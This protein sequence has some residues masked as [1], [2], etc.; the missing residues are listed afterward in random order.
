MF[1]S[2]SASSS[3][4][5]DS[6]YASTRSLLTG[7]PREQSVGEQLEEECCEG[8]PKLTYKQ[9]LVGF[10]ACFGIGMLIEFGSFFR[11]VQLIK[12][13]PKP[14]VRIVY[15][16]AVHFVVALQAI[17]YTLGNIIAIC[18]SFFL[19]GPWNQVKRMFAPTRAIATAIYLTSIFATLFCAYYPNIPARAGLIVLL[20]EGEDEEESLSSGET[21]TPRARRRVA[22]ESE[23]AEGAEEQEPKAVEKKSKTKD[24]SYVPTHGT[25]YLHD[26]RAK[27]AKPVPRRKR[28]TAGD[29]DVW[30]HDKY[31]ELV[32]SED[33]R[34]AEPQRHKKP[35]QS[36]QQQG[37]TRS[38]RRHR[39]PP[40]TALNPS[41][42]AFTPESLD[43][44]L[45]KL[46][47]DD[48]EEE[49]V[50][51]PL[52]PKKSYSAMRA[53]YINPNAT[54]FEASK[55]PTTTI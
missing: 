27:T 37:T 29:S 18:S 39:K 31:L 30:L 35:Q 55:L 17:C 26:D 50:A 19:S 14:F 9:R 34:S 46:Q 8:C 54:P 52:A 24:P 13:N 25:F 4:H 20:L 51:K 47:E 22:V 3:S 6:L 5:F 2:S 49:Y 32:A 11:I 10:V 42:E 44:A 12:G 43:I 36:R 41:A 53:S 23:E 21:L 40:Q 1:S 15:T 38:K 33:G 7:E 28:E 45:K 16:V 48:D